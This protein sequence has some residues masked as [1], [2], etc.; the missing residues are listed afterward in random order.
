MTLPPP[1]EDEPFRLRLH[2]QLDLNAWTR[3]GISPLNGLL[4][5][6]VLVSVVVAA[7]MTEPSLD[8]VHGLLKIALGVLAAVFTLEF[9]ARWWTRWEDPAWRE[10]RLGPWGYGLSTIALVD[11]VALIGVWSEVI[12]SAGIGWAV[13][14]RVLRLLRVFTLDNHSQ[15]GRAA[16]ELAAAVR[17]RRL[18]LGVAFSMALGLLMF[19]S[20][21]MFLAEGEAQPEIFGSI[22]RTAWWAVVTMTTV[23]YGDAYPTTW[24][25]KVIGAGAALSSIALIAVPAG[26]MASA[27]SDAVQRVRSHERREGRRP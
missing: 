6:A 8:T 12:L 5:T 3:P 21:A 20:V 25:G 19:F 13:M 14:L 17:D 10:R 9:A 15:L 26:I 22:P 23:G 1:S 27:F 2:R 24:L 11:L 4:V 7:L 16:H 18:E